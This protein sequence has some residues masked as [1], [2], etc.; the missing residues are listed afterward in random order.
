MGWAL[1]IGSRSGGAALVATALALFALP[2]VASAPAQ[3]Q[4]EAQR[5]QGAAIAVEGNRRIEADS[6]RSYFHPGT[7]G[8]L[9]AV[10]VDD[11]L[12][13]LIASGLF[14]DVRIGHAGD[15]LVVTVVENPV[16]HRVA[17]EG[18]R[19]VKTDQI[20]QALHSKSVG[21]FA[22]ATV[23][24]DVQRIAELERRSGRF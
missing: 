9:D 14:E 2:P 10:A 22:R 5:A 7:D 17:I 21:P 11:G 18:N 20:T 24:A 3:A 16:I 6:I 4:A 23:K 15:R 8:R 12:K 13:A 1:L 19:K